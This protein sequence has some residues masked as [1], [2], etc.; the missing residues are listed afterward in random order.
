MVPVYNGSS[1]IGKCLEALF[2]SMHDSFEVVVVDDCSSDNSADIVRLFPCR[3]IR[4]EERAGAS[5][6]R[7]VGALNSIGEI[8]FFIDSDCVV[9]PDTLSEADRT[10]S[11][12]EHM[13]FG[14]TY[15]KLPYDKGFFS[16]F[17][18]IFI[19]YS[20][21][22]RAEPDYIAG[23][24]MVIER[25]LFKRS[26]GFPED[27]LPIIEDVEFSHRLRR[28]GVKLMMN[29]SILVSH[30]FNFTL[31]GSLM[32][33]FRKARWWTIYSLHN[34]DLLGDSGTASIELK[35]TVVSCAVILS[36]L[37]IS[38]LSGKVVLLSAAPAIY[39]FNVFINRIFLR[40]LYTANGA[41]FALLSTLYYTMVFPFAVGAGSAT[42]IMNYF[43]NSRDMRK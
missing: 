23:H 37:I 18:S 7:N 15:T 40:E 21:T 9:R 38:L 14:G 17:Q 8:L 35:S 33:A 13:V 12:R 39:F 28:S 5:K 11:G 24:A 26:G 34:R 29:P 2:D 36:L 10:I 4:L 19:N 6:A 1:T 30:I 41:G 43:L 3:L 22:K 42:G 25:Q 27:F 32:N 20:E 16:T 31:L